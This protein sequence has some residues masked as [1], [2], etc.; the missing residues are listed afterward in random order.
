M[1]NRW[2]VSQKNVYFKSFTMAPWTTP[3]CKNFLQWLIMI[4]EG[5]LQP[6]SVYPW[7]ENIISN[8][9]ADGEAMVLRIGRVRWHDRLD[10]D[11]WEASFHGV[12]RTH[13]SQRR[14][15]DAWSTCGERAT[16]DWPPLRE[17]EA[18]YI[19]QGVA[20]K[21]VSFIK[22]LPNDRNSS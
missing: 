6:E 16:R 17:G 10:R 3:W 4:N 7:L 8:F 13:P 2:I 5:C 15:E 11:T 20:T 22:H 12:S 19:S 1:P 21:A 9:Y 14:E 18:K